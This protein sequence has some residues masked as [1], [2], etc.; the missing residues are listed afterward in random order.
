MALH[1]CYLFSVGPAES[2]VSWYTCNGDDV[3]PSITSYSVDDW[4]T[5]TTDKTLSL[6]DNIV[7]GFYISSTQTYLI[8]LR[9][10]TTLMTTDKI[11]W[12]TTP[13]FG[14]CTPI[15]AAVG[16]FMDGLK[17]ALVASEISSDI[18]ISQ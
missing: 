15:T 12:S 16:G 18:W 6:Y 10:G 5:W 4:T 1:A 17:F 8:A 7:G 9:N 11:T 2:P 3:Y 14:S 13:C